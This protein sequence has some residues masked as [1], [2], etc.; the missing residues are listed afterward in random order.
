VVDYKRRRYT[1]DALF[2]RIL[3]EVDKTEGR[4][5]LASATFHLVETPVIDVRLTDR[6]ALR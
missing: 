4:V 2:T 1:K 3:D 5:A 6:A